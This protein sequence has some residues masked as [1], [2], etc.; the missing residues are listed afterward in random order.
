MQYLLPCVCRTEGFPGGASGKESAC[1]C[2][3]HRKCRFTP[4]VG[5]IPWSRKWQPTPVCLSGEF[6]GQGSLASYSPWGCKESDTTEQ[7]TLSLCSYCMFPVT[8]LL[9][10]YLLIFFFTYWSINLLL[11][12]ITA[13]VL[14]FSVIS[15]W[16][17]GLWHNTE[18]LVYAFES[19]LW[20]QSLPLAGKEGKR[21]RCT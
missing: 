18:A 8:Y 4:W 10:R 14:F 13:L 16:I 2:R 15:W 21:E 7:R 11:F 12:D 19:F 1:Q 3:R 20:W 6:C 9:G 5:K 17:P